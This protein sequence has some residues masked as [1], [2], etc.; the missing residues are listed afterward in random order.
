[1]CV[2]F[3]LFWLI[4]S[5]G[6][7]SHCRYDGRGSESHINRVIKKICLFKDLDF[8]IVFYIHYDYLVINENLN[9][10]VNDILNIIYVERLTVRKQQH[11]Q[12]NLINNLLKQ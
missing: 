2:G 11:T 7:I 5:V 8:R 10:A 12:A 3:L 6:R 1:M 9:D 4:S